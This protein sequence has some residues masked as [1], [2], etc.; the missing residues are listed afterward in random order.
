LQGVTLASDSCSFFCG[1]LLMLK[2]NQ[3]QV[4]NSNN[5]KVL[6]HNAQWE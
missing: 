3:K 1:L 6:S 2:Q 4:F 5:N